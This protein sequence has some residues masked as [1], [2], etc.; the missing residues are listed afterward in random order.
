[1]LQGEWSWDYHYDPARPLTNRVGLVPDFDALATLDKNCTVI[2]GGSQGY[3]I[4][5]VACS[6]QYHFLCDGKSTSLNFSI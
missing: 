1:M 2:Q 6:D 3:K 5:P 4:K